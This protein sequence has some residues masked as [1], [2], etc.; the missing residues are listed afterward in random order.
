MLEYDFYGRTPLA[1]L[2]FLGNEIDTAKAI[3][4][5]CPETVNARGKFF[6]ETPLLTAVSGG[7]AKA[8]F[9]ELCIQ[10]GAELDA[11]YS[12]GKNVLHCIANST[13][14]EHLNV[15]KDKPGFPSVNSLTNDFQTPLHAVCMQGNSA[16]T[17]ESRKKMAVW[18]LDNGA[19]PFYKNASQRT[20]IEE[21]QAQ[22]LAELADFIESYVPPHKQANTFLPMLN[23]LR[24]LHDN[25]VE[26]R[27]SKNKNPS[28]RI[29]NF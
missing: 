10:Y 7:R 17:L 15:L 21:A 20:P 29:V 23:S 22:G 8:E 28:L 1:R 11:T 16:A 26:P 19:R 6:G 25:A 18:L 4:E 27:I 5:H 24:S 13:N 9:I 3:L 2:A 12:N 14:M